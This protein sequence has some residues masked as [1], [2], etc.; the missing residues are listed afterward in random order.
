MTRPLRPG[1]ILLKLPLLAALLCGGPGHAQDFALSVSPPRFELSAKAGETS[2]AAFEIENGSILAS[3]LSVATADWALTPAGAVEISATLKDDSCRPWVAIES[4]H[5]SLPGRSRTHFRFEVTPPAGT[6]PVECRFALVI[7]GADEQVSARGAGSLPVAGQIALIVYVAVGDVRP[8]IE[9]VKA[10]IANLDG[11][12]RPVLLAHNKGNAHGR[13]FAQLKGIDAAG[14]THEF[15]I[16][17][18]PVLPGETRA[19]AL[20]PDDSEDA[21]ASGS[22]SRPRDAAAP[23]RFPLDVSGTISDG[24]KSF[25]FQ[26]TFAP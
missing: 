7:S 18:L 9:V 26:G 10:D 20:E 3:D 24:D 11:T 23:I 21:I 14:K 2:R 1:L 13:L 8:D 5:L 19:L 6:P 12:S 16:S 4:H 22:D 25:R 15:A 17:T